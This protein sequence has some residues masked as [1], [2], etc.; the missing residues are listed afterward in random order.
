[1]QTPQWRFYV[2]LW[3]EQATQLQTILAIIGCLVS[4]VQFVPREPLISFELRMTPQPFDYLA[5][6]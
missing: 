2:P 3:K 6:Y 1:M 5:P 4:N